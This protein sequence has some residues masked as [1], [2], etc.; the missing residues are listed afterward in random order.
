MSRAVMDW[1]I[2]HGRGQLDGALEQSK[3]LLI[4]H[5]ELFTE[6]AKLLVSVASAG[7]AAVVSRDELR[8]L[9]E[10]AGVGFGVEALPPTFDEGRDWLVHAC[11]TFA[12]RQKSARDVAVVSSNQ[13]TLK[14]TVKVT[15]SELPGSDT[16]AND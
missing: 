15:S 6:V 1:A 4:R 10:A 12:G 5:S 2:F 8:A 7:V 13:G 14:A 11:D 16:F 9:A 3:T